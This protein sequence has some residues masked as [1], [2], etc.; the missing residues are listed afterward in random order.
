MSFKY[1]LKQTFSFLNVEKG[2][3]KRSKSSFNIL[4]IYEITLGNYAPAWASRGHFKGP[5]IFKSRVGRLCPTFGL[6]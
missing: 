6:F 2:L 3:A 4:K 1:R 5:V